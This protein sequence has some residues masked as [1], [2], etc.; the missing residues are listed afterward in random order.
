MKRNDLRTHFL[1][2][3][4]EDLPKRIKKAHLSW[5]QDCCGRVRT[6]RELNLKQLGVDIVCHSVDDSTRDGWIFFQ[7]DL[8]ANAF[9]KD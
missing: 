8:R 7:G 1:V 2:L 5:N 3:F 6:I 9:P 4:V